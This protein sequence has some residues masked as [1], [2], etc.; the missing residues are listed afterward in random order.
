MGIIYLEVKS[1][2][3]LNQQSVQGCAENCVSS[4]RHR[5]SPLP[6][7]L[8]SNWCQRPPIGPVLP[9]LP[10]Y[11]FCIVNNLDFLGFH[12]ME[13]VSFDRATRRID[14]GESSIG[15]LA[16]ATK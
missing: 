3:E 1:P 9:V 6:S 2:A 15:V 8:V 11:N 5:R 12:G 13:E 4:S 10:S 16:R 7:K 14:E